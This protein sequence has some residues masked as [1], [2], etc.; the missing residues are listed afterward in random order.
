MVYF[1]VKLHRDGASLTECFRLAITAPI[2]RSVAGMRAN[3]RH[4]TSVYVRTRE[5]RFRR[6]AVVRSRGSPLGGGNRFEEI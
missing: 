5:H 4:R 2:A 6:P 1:C 3:A